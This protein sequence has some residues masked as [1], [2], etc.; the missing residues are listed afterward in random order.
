MTRLVVGAAIVRAGRLLAARR[1][2]PPELAGR[3]EFPGGKVEPGEN[4][5]QALLRECREELGVEVTVGEP[6]E[7]EVAIKEDWRL[8][9]FFATL[10]AGEPA[11]R[12]DHDLLRWLA[13][14]ELHTVPWLPP[15]LPIVAA[16]ASLLSTE[17]SATPASANPANPSQ[18][19]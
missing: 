3:W 4:P 8:R 12:Q 11:P 7:P 1:T 5:E 15:D 13:G 19:R 17:H 9:V 16:I 10:T 2:G 18:P 14:D 6:V